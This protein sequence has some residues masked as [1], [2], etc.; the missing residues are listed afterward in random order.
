M[1]GHAHDAGPPLADQ[2][3][4]VLLAGPGLVAE[5]PAHQR[6]DDGHPPQDDVGAAGVDDAV[7]LHAQGGERRWGRRVRHQH[8]GGQLAAGG[9]PQGQGRGGEGPGGG[10]EHAARPPRTGRRPRHYSSSL[11]PQ[12]GQF[13]SP[14]SRACSSSTKPAPSRPRGQGEHADAQHGDAGGD[15]LARPGDRVVVAVA[16]GGQGDHPPPHGLGNAGELV[17]LVVVLDE[18]HERGRDHQEGDEHDADAGQLLPLAQHHPSEQPQRPRVAEQLREPEEAQQADDADEA[19]V[20]AEERQEEGQD[21]QQV[22]DGHGRDGEPEPA[23]HGTRVPGV[24]RA[25]PQAQPVLDGEDDQGD[26]LEPGEGGRVQGMDRG[27]RLQ[28]QGD[29]VEEDQP[30][31]PEVHGPAAEVAVGRYGQEM[32]DLLLQRHGVPHG[33]GVRKRSTVVGTGRW[34]HS[35][36]K[37]SLYSSMARTR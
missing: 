2:G 22:D 7:L 20:Q 10:A 32:V 35:T 37:R 13:R 26:A 23:Q 4:Q 28:G 25:R 11:C 6:I 34:C 9:R 16:D 5:A 3:L 17:G 27:H 15:E 33:A 14:P 19:H 12:L 30:Q 36:W 8:L 21:G 18:V 1:H 31:D 29:D 24:R